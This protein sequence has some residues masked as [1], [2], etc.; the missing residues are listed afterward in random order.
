MDPCPSTH[1]YSD[2][3][4]RTPHGPGSFLRP[5]V[6]ARARLRPSVQNSREPFTGASD[7]D[8]E[9]DEAEQDQSLSND[10]IT[11]E[12]HVS[13]IVSCFLQGSKST[14]LFLLS[15]SLA[16]FPQSAGLLE[17]HRILGD[18]LDDRCPISPEL[19]SSLI[20]VRNYC[21][22]DVPCELPRSR[23]ALIS[24]EEKGDACRLV[25]P[26]LKSFE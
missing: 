2:F 1:S 18:H 17:I 16:M 4:L 20:R 3:S 25:V 10:L 12:H 11:L 26:P 22:D 8:S 9:S 5:T 6:I 13:C 7:S 19:C 14:G 21:F 15:E 24:R 23:D